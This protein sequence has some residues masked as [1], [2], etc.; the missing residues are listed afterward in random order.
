MADQPA[1]PAWVIT[2]QQPTSDLG[3]GGSYVSGVKVTYRTAAGVVGSVFVAESDFTPD[4]VRAA[5]AA[6]AAASDAV[7]GLTG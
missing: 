7:A 2:Q 3:P 1:P 6:R 5:V 4:N